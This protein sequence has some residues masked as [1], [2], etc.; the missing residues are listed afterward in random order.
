MGSRVPQQPVVEKK[1]IRAGGS[2]TDRRAPEVTEEALEEMTALM[3]ALD[4]RDDFCMFHERSGDKATD[5]VWT[6]HGGGWRRRRSVTEGWW[7][8]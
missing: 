2:G 7:Q 3:A 5:W 6:R 4:L 8:G 1:Q